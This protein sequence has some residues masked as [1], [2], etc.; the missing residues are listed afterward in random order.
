[1]KKEQFDKVEGWMVAM[2]V[3][4]TIQ[5]ALIFYLFLFITT[6]GVLH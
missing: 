5:A 4:T 1:M 3:V 2:F 6:S